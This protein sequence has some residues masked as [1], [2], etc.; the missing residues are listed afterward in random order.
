MVDCAGLWSWCVTQS[1]LEKSL[2]NPLLRG[3][4]ALP[5]LNR[6]WGMTYRGNMAKYWAP[7][8]FHEKDTRVFQFSQISALPTVQEFCV[9]SVVYGFCAFFA[10]SF[11]TSCWKFGDKIGFFSHLFDHFRVNRK[12][13]WSLRVA[14]SSWQPFWFK[15]MAGKPNFRQ[16]VQNEF[17]IFLD[18]ESEDKTLHVESGTSKSGKIETLSLA[19]SSGGLS[20][21]S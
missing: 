4:W 6:F 12:K 2:I 10:N 5:C 16:L 1:I 3:W 13:L 20:N 21:F 15:N 14:E 19:P 11:S 7:L 17:S 18:L 9:W 8:V